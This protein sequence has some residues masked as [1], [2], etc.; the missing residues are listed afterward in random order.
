MTDDERTS[1]R[2]NRREFMT[3]S[4]KGIVGAAVASLL[5]AMSTG[6]SSKASASGPGNWESVRMTDFTLSEQYLYVNNSTL[7]TTLKAV[8]ERMAQVNRI[9]AEGCYLDRFVSEIIMTQAPI[10]DSFITLVNG[11]VDP[12]SRGR[13]AGFVLSVTEGMSLIANGLSFAA[14]DV[15][16]TTDHEHPGANTMWKLQADRYGARVMQIPL[17]GPMDTEATWRSNLVERL[18]QTC[19]DAWGRVRVVSFP[20]ITCSTGHVLPVSELCAVASSYGARSVVDAAQ[21]FAVVPLDVQSLGCDAMV[22]NGHKYLC[23]PVGSGFVTVHP[24]LIG[25]VSSFWPTIVDDNYY[26]PENLRRHYPYRKGGVQTY[27]NM[28][29]LAEALAQVFRLGMQTIARRMFEIG[30]RIRNDLAAYP[31]RFEI[32]TPMDPSSSSV[33][34]CFRIR[35]IPSESVYG[36][37]RDKYAIHCK[38]AT[39]GFPADASG[40]VNGAVRLSPHYY[41]SEDELL[42]IRRALYEIAGI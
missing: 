35:G 2:Y 26:H 15:I 4:G 24:R 38:H 27:T 32:I 39:E 14:G 16:I 7:G 12:A 41:V 23:G 34:T 8:Q 19:R 3:V 36:I 6:C 13:F 10:L 5:G 25:A 40:E 18:R 1:S 20:V 9:F 33:M 21:A 11:H 29:P 28:L 30:S 31:D 22:V 42:R 17:L 37:L